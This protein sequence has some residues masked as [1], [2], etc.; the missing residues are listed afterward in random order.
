MGAQTKAEKTGDSDQRNDYDMQ[1]ETPVGQW[2]QHVTR[3]KQVLIPEKHSSTG[4][5]FLKLF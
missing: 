2:M 4:V 5:I 3:L 1:T